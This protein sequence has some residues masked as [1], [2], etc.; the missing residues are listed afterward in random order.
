MLINSFYNQYNIEGKITEC[1][2][3]NEESIFSQNNYFALWRGQTNNIITHS[4]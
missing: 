1:W 2:L 3:V 4:Q